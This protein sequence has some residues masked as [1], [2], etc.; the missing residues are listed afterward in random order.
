LD[1]NKTLPVVEHLTY[2]RVA[3]VEVVV[4]VLSRVT[5]THGALQ[6]KKSLKRGYGILTA[7]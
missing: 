7:Y 1:L 3:A 4:V 2:Q 6:D 5:L